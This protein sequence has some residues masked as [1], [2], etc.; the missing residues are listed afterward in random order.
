[1]TAGDVHVRWLHGTTCLNEDVRSFPEPEGPGYIWM[2]GQTQ[3]VRDARRYLRHER[4][5]DKSRYSLTGYWLPRS[6]EWLERYKPHAEELS[7]LWERGEA[8][9]RDEEEIMDEYEAALERVGL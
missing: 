1:M 8:E 6:E 4:G 7:A 3:I 2:A 9:G 5:V